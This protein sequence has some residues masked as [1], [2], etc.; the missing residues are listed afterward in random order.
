MKING[1]KTKLI[2]DDHGYISINRTWK[3]ND[4]IDIEIPMSLYT[5]VNA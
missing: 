1:I 5:D 4:T 2:K 3:N